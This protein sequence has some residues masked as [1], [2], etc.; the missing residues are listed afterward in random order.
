M[1][2]QLLACAGCRLAQAQSPAATVVRQSRRALS[3]AI[4]SSVSSQYYASHSILP[5]LPF[6]HP[7]V[8]R[9][10][11]RCNQAS[12]KSSLFPAPKQLS[13]FSTTHPKQAT[14]VVLNPRT[15]DEGKPQMIDISPRAAQRL[16]EIT[17]PSSK[18]PTLPVVPEG[19]VQDHLRVTVSSGGCHGFQYLMTLD[20]ASNIDPEEDT[21]FEAES[22][23]S[24]ESSPDG[25]ALGEAKVVMDSA[26][27]ELLSGSTV[28]Y[29]MELIGSQ[30]K[31]TNNPR[32]TSSCG[33][34]TSFDVPA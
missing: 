28:D 22:E 2:Q 27:L 7:Y 34:G 25:K 21:I 15:D 29:T 6:L 14:R 17:D 26:T 20:S 13:A 9:P 16:R 5:K 12:R 1:N 8:Y 10:N 11:T 23:A 19:V 31:I 4:A 33:C 32:A 18:K 24:G 3:I 30:F